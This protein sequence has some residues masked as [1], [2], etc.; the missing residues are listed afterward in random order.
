VVPEGETAE[1][2]HG[3]WHDWR[4]A[5]DRDIRVRV[6]VPPGTRFVHMI[7]TL[8]GLARPGHVDEKGMPDPLQMAMIG[9]EFSDVVQFR[10]PPPAVQ[11]VM[12]SALAPL[13]HAMGYRGTYPQLSRSL[14]AGE[15]PR[16]L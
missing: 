12:F 10:S 7:G 9:R 1:A 16:G 14:L 4:K 8:H 2:G 6:E 11:K 5:T 13:A 3:L 15:A